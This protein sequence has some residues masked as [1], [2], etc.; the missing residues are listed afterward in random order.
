MY[1]HTGRY[2][3]EPINKCGFLITARATV[4]GSLSSCFLSCSMATSFFG[5]LGLCLVLHITRATPLVAVQ[6]Q[7][8]SLHSGKFVGAT[9]MGDIHAMGE[10]S[11]KLYD[12]C[13][14][15]THTGACGL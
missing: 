13:M 4:F 3:I 10:I 6:C 5:L 12:P 1:I 2:C 11:S 7:L 9:G 14:H 8:L 15:V